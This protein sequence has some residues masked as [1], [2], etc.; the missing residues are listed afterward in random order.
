MKFINNK[1][2]KVEYQEEINVN[3]Y[4]LKI[5][6]F[7]NKLGLE[8]EIISQIYLES[9]EL[10]LEYTDGKTYEEKYNGEVAQ[11]KI[12][13]FAS[14]FCTLIE[15]KRTENGFMVIPGIVLR[16]RISDN[17]HTF[18]HELFHALSNRMYLPYDNNGINY[19]KSGF[20]IEY[21]DKEDSQVGL[22]LKLTGLTEGMTELMTRMFCN[23]KGKN[24]YHFQL[25]LC[26]IILNSD[27]S[28]INAYFSRNDNDVKLFIEKILNNQST[29]NFQDFVN[30]PKNIIF[31]KNVIYKY[32]KG[33]IEYSLNVIPTE[34]LDSQIEDI[35]NIVS[36]LDNDLDYSFNDEYYSSL[37]NQIIEELHPKKL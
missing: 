34:R 35:K 32:L 5:I 30:L 37:V 6:Q 17:L 7:I 28:F 3:K 9:D 22:G 8:N 16:N 2:E 20:I 1:F 19:T 27:N 21:Y 26:S 29:L 15:Q 14:A 10:I 13:S 24:D 25:I 18:T 11:H 23:E 36:E 12:P 33:F 4:I 31:D